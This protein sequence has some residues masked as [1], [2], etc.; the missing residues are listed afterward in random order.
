M[1]YRDPVAALEIKLRGLRDTRRELD[2]SIRETR[3]ELRPYRRRRWRRVLVTVSVLA[4]SGLLCLLGAAFL[5]VPCNCG[6]SRADTARTTVR[7]LKGAASLYLARSGE[8]PTMD[9]LV[10][11]GILDDDQATTDPWDRP[12]R[13]ECRKGRVG[14]SSA[15]PDELHGTCDDIASWHRPR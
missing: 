8:C 12:F 6:P 7:T 10:E 4:G 3:R 13:I 2:A 15:G 14:V 1:P 9:D 11:R 5:A